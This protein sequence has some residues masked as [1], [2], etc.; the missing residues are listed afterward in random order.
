MNATPIVLERRGGTPE[1]ALASVD[2]TAKRDGVPL[3]RF[4]RPDEIAGPL[5]FLLSD[6]SAF[7]TGQC[8]LVDGGTTIHLPQAVGGEPRRS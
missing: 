8:I 2:A 5:L 7:I 3:G 1:E 6:L 4:G